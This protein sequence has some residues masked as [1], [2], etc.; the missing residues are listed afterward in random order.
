MV[1]L[2]CEE[3][4]AETDNE[5]RKTPSRLTIDLSSASSSYSGNSDE[6]S[7]PQTKLMIVEEI[8]KKNCLS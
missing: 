4:G 6:E 3:M 7:Q 1:S 2:S 5:S 8:T